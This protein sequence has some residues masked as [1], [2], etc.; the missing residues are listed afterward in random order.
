[1]GKVIS[2]HQ[3]LKEP[4]YIDLRKDIIEPGTVLEFEELHAGTPAVTIWAYEDD[5]LGSEVYNSNLLG[6]E[7]IKII[8]PGRDTD[9]CGVHLYNASFTDFK[10]LNISEFGTGLK[11][12]DNT[13]STVF[14]NTNIYRCGVA[15]KMKNV[16]TSGECMR[17][18]SCNFFNSYVLIESTGE[19]VT[20]NFFGCS[21][22]YPTG[23]FFRLHGARANLYGCH[24]EGDVSFMTSYPIEVGGNSIFK[25]DGGQID[26]RNSIVIRTLS[27]LFISNN[28]NIYLDDIRMSEIPGDALIRQINGGDFRVNPAIKINVPKYVK[29]GSWKRL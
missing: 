15:L 1:M 6:L 27:S 4:I 24:L 9:T 29:A 13:W 2:G 23:Y 10:Q 25:M 17:F 3:K 8:G 21:F 12:G 11:I 18:N 19:G 14:N 5:S 16:K 26:L 7:K 22:D 28:G 20:L